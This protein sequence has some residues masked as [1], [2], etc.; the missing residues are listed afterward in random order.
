LKRFLLQ[1]MTTMAQAGLGQFKG[2]Q[3]AASLAAARLVAVEIGAI[4]VVELIDAIAV[5]KQS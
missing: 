4:P 2:A 5:R 1:A 3:R